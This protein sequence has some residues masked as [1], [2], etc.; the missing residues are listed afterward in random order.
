MGFRL[1]LDSLP[2]VAEGEAPRHL[3]ADPFAARAPLPSR[4][5]FGQAV[6]LR[7]QARPGTASTA[8]LAAAGARRPGPDAGDSARAD[9]APARFESAAWIVRTAICVEAR[10]GVLY[11]FMP[12]TETLESY[13]DLVAAVESTAADLHLR[14]LLHRRTIHVWSGCSSRQIRVSSK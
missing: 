8:S 11:V 14:G 9:H 5:L 10:N 12:P 7:T 6:S 13:L 2:W 3:P 1:P 4:A